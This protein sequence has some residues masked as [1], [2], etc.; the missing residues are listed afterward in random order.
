MPIILG[1]M[2][3]DPQWVPGTANSVKPE[4]GGSECKESASNT[5]G[6]GLILGLGRSPGEGN[7][8]P[9]QCSCLGNPVGRGLAGYSPRG[10]KELDT[11][12][13]LTLYICLFLYMQTYDKV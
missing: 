12:E 11:T 7:D 3:Q 5:E 10:H 2:F 13:R 4:S 6:P 1:Y 9:L 8:N